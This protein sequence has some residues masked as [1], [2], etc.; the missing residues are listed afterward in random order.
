VQNAELRNAAYQKKNVE[1]EMQ[2]DTNRLRHLT[3][4]TLNDAAH[5]NIKFKNTENILLR[6]VV[7]I[8]VFKIAQLASRHSAIC[9]LTR[10]SAV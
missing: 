10:F 7:F 6:N 4:V 3:G 9:R 5:K 2:N 8:A 1:S